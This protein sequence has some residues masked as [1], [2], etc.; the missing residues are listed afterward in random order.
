MWEVE[1]DKI[2][3]RVERVKGVKRVKKV[4]GVE[5]VEGVK[6][7]KTVKIVQGVQIV[8]I[9]QKVIRFGEGIVIV[10]RSLSGGRVLRPGSL[11]LLSSRIWCGGFLIVRHGQLLLYQTVPLELL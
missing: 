10:M 2:V 4:K 5:G 1:R 7:D 6:R 3:K 8:Q 9:V 11:V